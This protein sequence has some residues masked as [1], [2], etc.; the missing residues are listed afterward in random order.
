MIYGELK[1]RKLH[2]MVHRMFGLLLSEQE[3]KRLM[4]TYYNFIKSHTTEQLRAMCGEGCQGERH[5]RCDGSEAF[6][7][8]V[9]GKRSE[10]GRV[11]D[12]LYR[13]GRRDDA[14]A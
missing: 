7:P 6:E 12:G 4:E 10:V 8:E 1:E 3:G 11:Q 9:R 2:T 14:Q 5:Q 13:E